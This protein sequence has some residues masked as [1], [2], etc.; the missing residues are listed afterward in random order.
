MKYMFYNCSS[1]TSLN[2]SN[3]NAKFTD[4]E[5]MFKNCSSLTSLYTEDE[6]ILEQLEN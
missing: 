2:L 6:I 1:L 5:G 3:F 4:V